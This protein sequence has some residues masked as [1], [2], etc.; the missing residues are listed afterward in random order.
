[1]TNTFLN[2][3]L[4]YQTK[5]KAIRTP[6]LFTGGSTTTVTLQFTV[7][8]SHSISPSLP[9]TSSSYEYENQSPV[10]QNSPDPVNSTSDKPASPSAKSYDN[11]G[12]KEPHR[13]TPSPP[14][15]DTHDA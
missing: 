10:S 14:A 13:K 11:S 7:K 1:L 5:Q 3:H 6:Q 15:F 4:V 12:K 2:Q 9:A 8:S